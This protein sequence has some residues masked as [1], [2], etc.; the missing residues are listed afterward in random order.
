M[1]LNSETSRICRPAPAV[2][3]RRSTQQLDQLPDDHQRHDQQHEPVERQQQ[4]G[5]SGVGLIGVRPVRIAKV[6]RP[7]TTPSDTSM[8]PAQAGKPAQSLETAV[9]LRCDQPLSPA[10]MSNLLHGNQQ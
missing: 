1:R 10:S 3:R 9:K 5:D 8:K 6:S 4:R 7:Q 2:P